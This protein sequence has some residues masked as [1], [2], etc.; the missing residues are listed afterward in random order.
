MFDLRRALNDLDL[1]SDAWVGIR[2][3]HQRSQI[4]KVT[5]GRPDM[6]HQSHNHGV[7]VEVL[8][9]GQF[10]SAATCHL[11]VTSVRF[12][13]WM[14]YTRAKAFAKNGVFKFT[15]DQ[16]PPSRGKF[17]T[18]IAKR[19][20]D[21]GVPN[22]VD[23]LIRI[24]SRLKVSPQIVNTMALFRFDD[25]AVRYVSRNGADIEQQFYLATI[26]FSAT[27]ADGNEVQ[28]RTANGL[29]ARSSQKGFELLDA[30]V[31]FP[32]AIKTGED[33]VALLKA[34]DCPKDTCSLVL[35]PDQMYMQI[36]ESI[37]HPL[38][39]DRILG[40]EFNYAGSSFV[41]LEDFGKLQYGSP[42]L[43]VVYDPS[44]EGEYASFAFDDLGAP[45]KKEFLIENGLLKRGL[46][47]LESQSRTQVP[48]VANSR[49]NYWNR[50]PIDRMG[51]INILP[52][53]K[54]LK[55]L[56]RG[57]EKGILM[58]SNRSWSID[59]KRENF[60]FGCEFGQRIENGELKG[61]VKNPNYRGHTLKF[62][63]NLEDLGDAS[64]WQ[65]YGSPFCGKGEPNQT[66]RVGHASPVAHFK[67]VEIFGGRE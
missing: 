35:M 10:A 13:G 43:N 52:G 28:T 49:S 17:A 65:M 16:R 56:L 34:P 21:I 15:S 42:K 48:G 46:G 29:W 67:D 51:N 55:E 23:F 20:E 27:A 59:D 39:L 53:D 40:D 38:E 58:Q 26:D 4:R 6:N 24:G 2:E 66:V 45:A 47:G 7:M 30:D 62:W 64:T 1:P 44:L 63:R 3:V 33:A 14:A 22:V 50:Q 54:S 31:L 9:D 57:V 5:D 8:V 19:I 37:G 61:L 25:V 41:S 11:D 60:Q 18:K 32:Q 12:A 36:H